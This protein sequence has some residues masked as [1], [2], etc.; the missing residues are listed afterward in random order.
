VNYL[1]VDPGVGGGLALLSPKGLVLDVLTMPRD[2]GT[3]TNVLQRIRN[4][5][6][7]RAALEHVRSSP[8]MGV[9][10]AFTFG[11]NYERCYSLLVACQI[12]FDEVLP[13]RWQTALDCR[14]GGDKNITKRR[15]A[16]LFTET[17]VTHRNA[18]AL[19]L[20][21]YRRRIGQGIPF[22]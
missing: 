12:P 11:R 5:G 15:A 3:L 8:Q 4:R 1:G 17:H 16:A 19:L 14:S 13:R 9:V 7:L 10:S 22:D 20:A 18:D 21:E 2:P 6:E